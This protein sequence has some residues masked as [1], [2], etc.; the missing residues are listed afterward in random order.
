MASEDRSPKLPPPPTI[1]GDSKAPPRI[2]PPALGQ[3]K[4]DA[5]S[6]GVDTSFI[7]GLTAGLLDEIPGESPTPATAQDAVA[8]PPDDDDDDLER[9]A[10]RAFAAM[11][12]G[13]E[14]ARPPRATADE[15]LEDQNLEDQD[16]EDQDLEDQ[17]L[18]DQDL[19]D[20][21]ASEGVAAAL[22]F[23][24][25]GAATEVTDAQP[26]AAPAAGGIP[27]SW[28]IVGVGVAIALLIVWKSSGGDEPSSAST[29]D[30][31][32]LREHAGEEP[33]GGGG[34][35]GGGNREGGEGHAGEGGGGHDQAQGSRDADD[36]DGV[37]ADAREADENADAVADANGAAE[38]GETDGAAESDED[39]ETI[40]L[41]EASQM[42]ST[43]SSTRSGG[44]PKPLPASSA[45]TDR[46]AEDGMSAEELL[47]AAREAYK[48]GKVRDAYRLANLSNQKKKSD[49]AL[50][51]KAKSACRMK[52]KDLAKSA[53]KALPM[54]DKRRDV[55][56]TCREHDVRL[57]L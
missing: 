42:E 17:D 29:E 53:Y 41:A 3:S 12:E 2:H 50:E 31:V 28:V 54:G 21:A 34:L 55:R 24:P 25:P 33:G 40:E 46:A 15:D 44:S 37:A 57:G 38:G 52:N 30:R 13:G 32:A 1:G 5:R 23:P 35:D 14:I 36:P 27:R 9:L 7:D 26:P 39:V 10:T 47:Q 22:P 4:A 19:E 56:Q 8:G 48:K 20:Q 51:L 11:D 43:S 45:S 6:V 18:E 16:L 49:D